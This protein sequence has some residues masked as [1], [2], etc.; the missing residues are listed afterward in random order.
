M[1]EHSDFIEDLKL[2][3]IQLEDNTYISFKGDYQEIASRIGRILILGEWDDNLK[4]IPLRWLRSDHAPLAL[5][6][7]HETNKNYFKFENCWPGT[8]GFN[9]RIKD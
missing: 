4:Q 7:E 6:G 5:Q 9:V 2:I 1:R 3:D 8:E